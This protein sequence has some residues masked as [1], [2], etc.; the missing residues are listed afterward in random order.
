[1]PDGAEVAFGSNP[2]DPTDLRTEVV[3]D[4]RAAVV[5]GPI[6]L[7]SLTL[8]NGAV[9]T[10]GAS[11][12]SSTSLLQLE[13]TGTLTIDATS[14]I[15]VSGRGFLGGLTGVNTDT[16]GRTAGNVAGS[17]GRSG[18]SHGGV[19]GV[20]IVNNPNAA[21]AVYDDVRAPSQPGGGGATACGVGNNNG[22]GVVRLTAK[23]VQ[24][25]G[26]IASDGASSGNGCSGGG[27]GGSIA[28][29]VG[30]LTGGGSIHA[31][32]GTVPGG[33][34]GTGGGG[35]GRIAVVYD[36]ASGFALDQHRGARWQRRRRT[37]RPGRS[38]SNTA[39]RSAS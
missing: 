37:A 10:T 23:T 6:R 7:N 19:G 4:G 38:S 15:D 21:A 31:N 25:D 17:T 2:N 32:G 34:N 14:G 18:A 29:T 12:A 33:G 11:T 39:A 22:G 9:L 8:R 36:S 26:T 3:I 28:L 5:N 20:G 1:M 16:A 13:L 27:A 24:L 35:G 30:T